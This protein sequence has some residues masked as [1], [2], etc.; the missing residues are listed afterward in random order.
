M[1]ASEV[2]HGFIRNPA[3]KITRFDVKGTSNTVINAI[4]ASG[5]IAGGYDNSDGTGGGFVIGTDGA[6]ITFTVGK[7]KSG[8]GVSGMND[9]GVVAG[10][11]GE[12]VE[13]I[14][15]NAVKP[16]CGATDSISIAL[17]RRT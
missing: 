13:G 5:Q 6:V 12:G 7:S 17:R 15:R 10:S 11:V 9:S 3:G 14:R 4:N 8:T 1:D 2:E 16:C